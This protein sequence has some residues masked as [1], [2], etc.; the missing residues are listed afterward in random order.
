MSGGHFEYKEYSIQE[1]SDS[2]KSIIETN[3]SDEKNIY[4]EDVS[5]KFSEGTIKKMRE[6]VS[7]LNR[8]F[9]YVKKI[10]LLVSGDIGEETFNKE[11]IKEI[12]QYMKNEKI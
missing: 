4:G 7:L 5:Y 6:A 10:D 1:I 9:I 8:A 12:F 11:M 2:I 3:D